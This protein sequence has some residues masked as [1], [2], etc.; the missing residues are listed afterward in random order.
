L[1]SELTQVR[2]AIYDIRKI[3]DQDKQDFSAETQKLYINNLSAHRNK[4]SSQCYSPR[5][6]D[7][8]L[9][10]NYTNLEAR[11]MFFWLLAMDFVIVLVYL[12]IHILFSDMPWGPARQL[13]NIDAEVSIPT[14]FSSIQLF[15]TGSMLFVASINNQWKQYVSSSFLKAGSLFFIFL[16]VDES[17]AIHEK[18]TII[19]KKLG[20]HL[21]LF[22]GDHGAWIAVY[23]I[24]AI[25]GVLMNARHF[26]NLWRYFRHENIIALIGAIML[27]TGGIVFEI[28][29][30]LFLRS[31][32]MK[33]LYKV[34][35]AFEEFFEMSGVS[36]IL[37]AV[38]LLSIAISTTPSI[39]VSEEI[40]EHLQKWRWN[41]VVFNTAK[42]RKTTDYS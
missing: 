24:I 2:V 28:I 10:I 9:K 39:A 6:K 32:S 8:D 5:E 41:K 17:A 18:I 1:K 35:V 16:S 33:L 36:I 25:V 3:E 30:Y 26:R 27:V 22:K 19:A 14:W 11:K 34:E 31:E 42:P 37:Y 21:I 23:L 40:T 20:I 29:S 4:M 15:V 38:L 12:L 7:M 13:F